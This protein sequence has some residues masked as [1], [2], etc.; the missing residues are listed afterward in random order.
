MT[1]FSET[2]Q[3]ML[4]DL[5]EAP[6]EFRPTNFWSTGLPAI[7]HDIEKL[8]IEG[9]RTHP[10]A[11]FFYVPVYGSKTLR[12]YGSWLLP[13][14]D[15]L[16]ARKRARMMKRLTH[17]DRAALDYRLFRATEVEGGL[18]L[19]VVSESEVGAGERFIFDA[20]RYSRS[21]L[22]YLR[23][24]NL[25]K[26]HADSAA[27][28]S[29]LEIGGGYG[30]L[31]EILLKAQPEGLYVNV[32]IPPVAAVSTWYLQQV[33]G[34]E[35]VLDY[36]QS[37]QMSEI[38]LT[39]IATRYKAAVL[40]P[41]QLPRVKGQVDLFVNFMSFQE[42]EPDV[43]R[44]YVRLVQPLIGKNVLMR[45]SAV[46]KKVAQKSGEVGVI[47]QVKSGFVRECFDQ[48]E[49]LATDAFVYGETNESGSY[50]SEVSVMARIS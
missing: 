20:R 49:T 28:Q 38:D 46:G 21:M 3:L 24:L 2:L 8:G 10:S 39:E 13:L 6:P 47:D 33:F 48:F 45:N 7:I 9:F 32:D 42:M 41:W 23:G 29:C 5:E 18:A 25:Y 31:G 14:V 16:P 40:C 15:K 17:S 34:A 11:T 43:V 30:T 50:Q 1:G 19:D 35:N 44:N 22:N 12:R 37:R 4:D 26:R 36:A 27:W